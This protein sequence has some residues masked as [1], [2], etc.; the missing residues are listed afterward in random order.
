MTQVICLANSWKHGERCIA[1][2]DP[3]TG[4]WI[5]PVSNLDDGRVPASIR[6][7]QGQEPALLDILEIPVE[8]TGSDFGFESENLT[9]ASGKWGRIEKFQATDVLKYCGSYPYILHNSNKYVNVTYLQSLPFQERRTL[10]LVYAKNFSVQSIP[11]GGGQKWKGTL[12]TNTGQK[13]TNATITDP[14]FV[15]KLEFGYYPQNPCLVTVSLSMPHRPDDWEGD[16]PC[17]KIIAG[18][19]ELSASDLILVEMKRLNWSIDQGREYLQ[20][21]YNKRSRQQ[22]TSSEITEFLNYLQSQSF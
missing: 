4:K 1:G 10:Q 17:W 8:T 18:V 21:S 9:I 22:L 3:S 13:L 6:C 5:R 2:I 19:I 12:E 14:V 7:I 16:D 20:R 11:Q 15:K